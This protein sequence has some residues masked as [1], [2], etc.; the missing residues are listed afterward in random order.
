MRWY[1]TFV[2]VPPFADCPH[3]GGR[4]SRAE[5]GF[6]ICCPKGRECWVLKWEFEGD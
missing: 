6:R 4:V 5:E 1:G 2:V 3:G